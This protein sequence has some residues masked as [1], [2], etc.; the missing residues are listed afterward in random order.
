MK[1][2]KFT[3]LI[4]AAVLSTGAFA[5]KKKSKYKQKNSTP[6]IVNIYFNLYTDSLKKGFYNYISV[7]GEMSDGSWLPLDS[8]HIIF[9]SNAGSFKGNDIFLDSSWKE[10]TIK[11]KAVLRSN[12]TIWKE[13]TIYI[14]K[15]GFDELLKTNEQILDEMKNKAK[16][17]KKG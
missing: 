14:R 16:K 3:I 2:L 9:T 12:S 8:S 15:R 7:D 4:L 17:S 1:I 6:E 10:E 11:V 13:T 5:Q